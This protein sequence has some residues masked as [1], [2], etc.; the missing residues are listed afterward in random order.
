[1][2][3]HR[4][5]WAAGPIVQLA[6]Q[7]IRILYPYLQLAGALDGYFD[8]DR[9]EEVAK[10]IAATRPDILWV[11]V[12]NPEQLILA[13][14]FKQLIPGLTWVRTCGPAGSATQSAGTA[15][16]VVV[17]AVVGARGPLLLAA[18]VT[19]QAN[20]EPTSRRAAQSTP[21]AVTDTSVRACTSPTY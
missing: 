10:D 1:M 16:P 12:G 5:R 20:D 7:R 6:I 8:R 15:S 2:P 11:G 14:K 3:K 17:V 4:D 9:I 21:A 13:H 18:P 19:T